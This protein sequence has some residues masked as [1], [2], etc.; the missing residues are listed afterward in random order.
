MSSLPSLLISISA[1]ISA[2]YPLQI[3]SYNYIQNLITAQQVRSGNETLEF[4]N[5]AFLNEGYQVKSRFRN[6]LEEDFLSSVETVQ[7]SNSQAAAAEINSWVSDHTHNKIQNL[8][9]P[10]KETSQY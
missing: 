4:A 10:G 3:R 7:F 8:V 2:K 1:I 6:I 5:G 9:S